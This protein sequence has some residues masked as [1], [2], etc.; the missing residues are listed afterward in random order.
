MKQKILLY[1][2][3][4]TPYQGYTWGKYEQTVLHFT[5]HRELLSIAWQWYGEKTIH[6]ATRQGEK[7]DLNLAKLAHGLLSEADVSIAHNGDKFD[8]KVLKARFLLNKLTP[9]K[10]LVSVDTCKAARNYFSFRGNSLSDL[11]AEMKVG[12]KVPTPGIQLWLD[13]MADKKKA[14]TL[15]AK[16]NKH[17]VTLLSAVY[18]RLRPYIENHPRVAGAPKS[19]GECP[20]CGS[21]NLKKDGIRYNA[22]GAKQ[23]WACRDCHKPFM[24]PYKAVAK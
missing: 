8:K 1:D 12:G 20:L 23:R 22:S 3:E 17:D 2:I 13:C 14:W 10:Q 5:Q 19:T 6:V 15:M 24:T 7:T 21:N 16:Y 9:L 11:C 4:T 18:D